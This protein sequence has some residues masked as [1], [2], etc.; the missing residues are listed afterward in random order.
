MLAH[1]RVLVLLEEGCR[2]AS[3]QLFGF[4]QQNYSTTTFCMYIITVGKAIT[5]SDSKSAISEELPDFRTE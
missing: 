2:F 1:T 5:Q 4:E 3:L